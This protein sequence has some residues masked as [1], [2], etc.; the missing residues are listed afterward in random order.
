ML[1]ADV[2]STGGKKSE[3]AYTHSPH[4]LHTYTSGTVGKDAAKCKGVY[5]WVTR[6]GATRCA[7]LSDVGEAAKSK[8]TQTQSY[9]I[10][11]VVQ[12]SDAQR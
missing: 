4:A 1:C 12:M 10:R 5:I 11:K 8:L 7:G 2:H 9:S 3:T 6:S